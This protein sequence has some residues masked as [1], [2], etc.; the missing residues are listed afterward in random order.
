MDLSTG[1]CYRIVAAGEKKSCDDIW[2]T[3]ESEGKKKRNTNQ[4]SFE[5]YLFRESQL[6]EKFFWEMHLKTSLSKEMFGGERNV[7]Q[8][9]FFI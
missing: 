6:E 1:G 8:K 2:L 7:K 3:T 5:K 9:C 4:N